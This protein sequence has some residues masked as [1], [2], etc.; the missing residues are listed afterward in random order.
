VVAQDGQLQ[1][2]PGEQIELL[3][4]IVVF[5]GCALDVEMTAPAAQIDSLIAPFIQLLGEFLQREVR[6][7]TAEENNRP[8]H[9]WLVFGGWCWVI[10]GWQLV[11]G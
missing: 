4:A 8:R 11:V 2:E 9:G 7:L 3:L 1:I 5:V 6:P 10:L